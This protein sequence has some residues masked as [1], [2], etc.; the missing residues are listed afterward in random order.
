MNF[1]GLLLLSLVFISTNSIAKEAAYQDGIF[2]NT[3][4]QI[5]ELVKRTKPLNAT[6]LK[7]LVV[8]N[9]ILG[10]TFH[11]NSI[12]ELF[13][14]AD[15]TLLFRKS[16][17]PKQIYVGKW[18]IKGDNIYSQ[19]KTYAK[20]PGVNQLQYYHVIDNIYVY[21]SKNEACGKKHQFCKAFMVLKGD[22]FNLN[23]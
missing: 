3:S 20:N 4:S 14:K 13:F 6:T 12:Y 23:Q 2:K 5:T 19:W 1:K 17:D 8:N 15:G 22:P 9:T 11:S 21:F 18:W 10:Y 16:R 7:K